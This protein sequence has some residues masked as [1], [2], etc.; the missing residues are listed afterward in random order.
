MMVIM[1]T[2]HFIEG[3]A[4]V[5]DDA[6]YVVR[7][8]F[9]MKVDVSTW[10][11]IHMIGGVCVMLAG[12]WLMFGSLIARIVAIFVAIVS[13]IYNFYSIPYYPVWSILLIALDIAVIWAVTTYGR[14]MS[15]E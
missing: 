8:N 6:F 5:L 14:Y 11:W 1:G 2:F 9:S 12:V 7:P 13:A 4:A 15:S 3:L 10:G